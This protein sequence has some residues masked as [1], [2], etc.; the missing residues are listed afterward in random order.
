[1]RLVSCAMQKVVSVLALYIASSLRCV[2]F[3]SVCPSVWFTDNSSKSY[4]EE[5]NLLTWLTSISRTRNPQSKGSSVW[6]DP[7]S[8]IILVR[9]Y[10]LQSIVM[11]SLP[12]VQY[13]YGAQSVKCAVCQ[14]VTPT[15]A[16]NLRRQGSSVQQP[17]KPPTQTV[18]VENPSTLDEQ[19]NE[20][21][22]MNLKSHLD[23]CT[24]FRLDTLA[25]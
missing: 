24:V 15:Q 5:S 17:P 6:P 14:H 18:V 16:T 13:A 25:T 8:V 19:G 20:V 2:V 12:D 21:T 22:L 1:M 4:L 3:Y 7:A 23:I 11:R 10:D 9:V